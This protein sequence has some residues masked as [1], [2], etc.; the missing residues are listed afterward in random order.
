[1]ALPPK[2]TT[3]TV[4]PMTT[5]AATDSPEVAALKAKLAAAEAKLASAAPKEFKPCTPGTFETYPVLL[6]VTMDNGQEY[7]FPFLKGDLA[8][9]GDKAGPTTFR[10]AK[11]NAYA[12]GKI[13]TKH[14]K[15]DHFQV[16]CNVTQV[17]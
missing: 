5:P 8:Q 15:P 10:G 12:G 6:T 3:Q 2:N 16:G 11:A 1:M 13:G 17:L 4:K 14:T 7:S 9:A